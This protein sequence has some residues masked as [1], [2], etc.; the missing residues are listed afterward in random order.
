MK[1]HSG[2][3]GNCQGG[4][5]ADNHQRSDEPNSLPNSRL[6]MQTPT[7]R[8]KFA[9]RAGMR[10]IMLGRRVGS[11]HM[12]RARSTE[13]GMITACERR[14]L[15]FPLGMEA[16]EIRHG[17]QTVWVGLPG[18]QITKV[19]VF[20]SSAYGQRTQRRDYRLLQAQDPVLRSEEV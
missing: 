5:S 7:R 13:K 10:N 3:V 9:V 1:N 12:I 19:L 8:T 16:R 11:A 18:P 6:T 2:S 17:A 20:G 15:E 4:K 14:I